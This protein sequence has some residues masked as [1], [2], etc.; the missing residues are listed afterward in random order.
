MMFIDLV[1]VIQ[2]VGQLERALFFFSLKMLSV[3]MNF[4]GHVKKFT[5]IKKF[6]AAKKIKSVF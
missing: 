6:I 3:F 4:L 1:Q 2:L 5:C